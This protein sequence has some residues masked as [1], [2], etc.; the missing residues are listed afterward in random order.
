M[1][2]W[3]V[4]AEPVT[5]ITSRCLPVLFETTDNGLQICGCLGTFTTQR[6]CTSSDM[7]CVTNSLLVIAEAWLGRM[8]DLGN[9]HKGSL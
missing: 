1:R 5:F 3:R 9:E 2:T 6:F 4:F 7:A 8:Y